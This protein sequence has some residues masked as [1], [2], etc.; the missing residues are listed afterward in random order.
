MTAF[1]H[2]CELCNR[3]VPFPGIAKI[4]PFHSFLAFSTIASIIG[5]HRQRHNACESCTAAG[6]FLPSFNLFSCSRLQPLLCFLYSLLHR[7]SA[8]NIICDIQIIRQSVLKGGEPTQ[9]IE[10]E[11][12]RARAQTCP[13]SEYPPELTNELIASKS[14]SSKC[15]V[16][17]FH[18]GEGQRKQK[19]I[20][21]P[22]LGLNG[23]KVLSIRIRQVVVCEELYY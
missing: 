20:R 18:K 1:Q 3:K 23:L 16:L 6:I 4:D 7:A 5:M 19:H 9:K 22:T 15:K 14:H 11:Q 13:G 2:T 17:R 10:V 21:A 12:K 8:L